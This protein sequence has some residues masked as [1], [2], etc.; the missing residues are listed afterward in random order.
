M[1][2]YKC[3]C[4]SSF[5]K[6]FFVH[7]GCCAPQ[8]AINIFLMLAYNKSFLCLFFVVLNL[9]LCCYIFLG[10]RDFSA[11]EKCVS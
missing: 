3:V 5:L 8:D 4:V 10:R 1:N 11:V 9:N 6:N 7:G 2:G